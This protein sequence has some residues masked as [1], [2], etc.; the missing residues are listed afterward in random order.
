MCEICGN[1]QS[2]TNSHALNKYHRKR[3][4]AYFTKIK[5]GEIKNHLSKYYLKF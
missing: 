1:S 2:R 3:L 4:I 5:N